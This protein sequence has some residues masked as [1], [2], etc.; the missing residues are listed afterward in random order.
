MPLIQT[1]LSELS[2]Y[3]DFMYLFDKWIP[4][5]PV[6][7]HVVVIATRI[8]PLQIQSIIKEFNQNNSTEHYFSETFR[9]IFTI[10]FDI[11]LKSYQKEMTFSTHFL[12]CLIDLGAVLF[13]E[14]FGKRRRLVTR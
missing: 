4:K 13:S 9:E 11:V 1:V 14:L 6:R 3:T 12:E 5:G 10:A 7:V 2:S 8:R